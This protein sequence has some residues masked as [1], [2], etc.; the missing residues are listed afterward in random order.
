MSQE[1]TEDIN[2]GCHIRKDINL[3]SKC[4]FP[5]LPQNDDEH[6]VMV[7]SYIDNLLKRF[8]TV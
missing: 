2:T 3:I 7:K 8:N 6:D 5:T 4:M 1:N